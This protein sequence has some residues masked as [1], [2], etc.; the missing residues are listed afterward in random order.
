MRLCGL[1]LL[2]NECQV[3]RASNNI[4]CYQQ[5]QGAGSRKCLGPCGNVTFRL[6]LRGME[7]TLH[8]TLW[9]MISPLL[10]LD[11]AVRCR[12]VTRRWN[13]S[14]RYGEMGE[15]FFQLLHNDPFAKHWYYDSEGNK[16]YTVLRKRNPFMEGF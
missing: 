6:C 11:D 4:D 14:S 7:E 3:I 16:T 5:A 15:M 1:G 12:T 9:N 10:T 8:G 2:W 13:M